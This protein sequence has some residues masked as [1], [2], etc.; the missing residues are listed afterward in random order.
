MMKEE[1]GQ[2]GENFWAFENFEQGQMDAIVGAWTDQ[3]RK[4]LAKRREKSQEV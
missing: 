1:L 3:T 4:T 2:G